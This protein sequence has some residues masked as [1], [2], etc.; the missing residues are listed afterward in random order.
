MLLMNDAIK[1]EDFALHY[2]ENAP[3][4]FD[5]AVKLIVASQNQND[6]KLLYRLTDGAL[7]NEKLPSR[8]GKR[9]IFIHRRKNTAQGLN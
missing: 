1:I 8:L 9:A 5:V 7:R 4:D 2:P 6:F 3:M